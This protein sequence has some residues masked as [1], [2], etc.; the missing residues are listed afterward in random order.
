MRAGVPVLNLR[1]GKPSA[2]IEDEREREDWKP[3][4]PLSAVYS[5]IIILLFRY[6][7]VATITQP[8]S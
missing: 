8:A 5:P 1:S 4:G 7:P 2:S 3:E 6:T